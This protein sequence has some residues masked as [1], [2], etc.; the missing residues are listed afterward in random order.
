VSRYALAING[1]GV[2]GAVG[3]TDV[4]ARLLAHWVLAVLAL[5]CA[6]AILY[7]ARRSLSAP[8]IA[9]VAAFVLGGLI[10]GYAYPSVVQKFL[11]QPSQLA[12]E[13]P[14][15]AW[16]LEFTRRAFGLDA[17]DRVH[18]EYAR[19]TDETFE[20]AAPVLDN[21][22][23]WDVDQ[24]Q[25]AFNQ[26]QSFQGYYTF[27]DVDLDRYELQGGRQEVGIAVR[28][29]EQ[30]GLPAASRNW[31]NLHLR[32]EFTR[33]VGAVVAETNVAIG[34]APSYLVG[35]LQPIRTA[36]A[37]MPTLAL[38]QASVYYGEL[39]T[40]YIVLD[41]A[42]EK[43]ATLVEGSGVGIASFL[44][45]LAFAW[46]FG[47]HN[48]L[49]AR[50][51]DRTSRLLFRRDVRERAAALAPFLQWDPDALPV[52]A[53][54]RV[55]WILD[56]Y[57]ASYSFPMSSTHDVAALQL[58][59]IN[60]LRGS[61]KAVIDAV[62]GETSFY[63]TGPGDAILQ[64]YARVFPD[65][66]QPAAE[67]PE[68]VRQHLRYPATLLM[69]QSDVLEQY[70]V[71][72]ARVFFAGEDAWEVP[73]QGASR[74]TPRPN[75]PLYLLLP[76]PG[77]STAGFVSLLP[78]TARARQN[79]T[80][81]L[82]AQNDADSY[83][84]LTLINFSGDEQ[85]RGP[86]QIQSLIEQDPEISQQLSLWRQLGTAVELGQLRILPVGNSILYVEPLF[87]AAEDKAIPQLHRVLVSDGEI[88]VMANTLDAAVRLLI[89]R[90]G[91]TVSARDNNT[92][93]GTNAANATSANA[94]SGGA[95]AGNAATAAWPAEALQL[96]DQA[97]RQLRAGDF[98]A[99]GETWKQLRAV[100]QEAAGGQ[101]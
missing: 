101:R 14:Y 33:G 67:M 98:A 20:G 85:I 56:G 29:F 22:A 54:G 35:E 99:F 7:G 8:V 77:D 93:N 25:D 6:A 17:I 100:L 24:L 37:A 87:L 64:S 84:R 58:R 36:P 62:T 76:V 53:N 11:V 78:F 40:G 27:E 9:G 75:E 39:S 59:G 46:R 10:F 86:A 60:Y 31:F 73:A 88:A 48:L 96:Y 68:W 16:N 38:P 26:V 69:L 89:S 42:S 90:T 50:D 34:G 47:D 2:Q 92:A 51:L 12:R 55:Y 32:P 4:H 5:L 1:T 94:T 61:V 95:A 81:M 52:V 91:G 74:G 65:L 82:I 70:H 63:A 18:V 71:E 80:A 66:I 44:R 21:L 57:T 3:Y 19:A 15:I 13:E 30:E 79:L 28:E 45:V 41:S 83:G 72:Q 49:F 97:E 43:T 23:L